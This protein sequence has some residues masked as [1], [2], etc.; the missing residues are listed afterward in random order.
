MAHHSLKCFANSSVTENFNVS[1]I[2]VHAAVMPATLVFSVMISRLPANQYN[3]SVI[4]S[5]VLTQENMS[6][7]PVEFHN[8]LD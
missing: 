7:P 6:Q 1:S 8:N 2:S 4:D 3:S 5:T